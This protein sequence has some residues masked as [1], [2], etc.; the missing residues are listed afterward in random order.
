MAGTIICAA[1]TVIVARLVHDGSFGPLKFFLVEVQVFEFPP[2]T[3]L[4]VMNMEKV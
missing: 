3:S 2:A 4:R 1:A